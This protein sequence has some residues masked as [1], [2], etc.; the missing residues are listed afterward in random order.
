LFRP[1]PVFIPARRIFPD[2]LAWQTAGAN[3]RPPWRPDFAGHLMAPMCWK[4]PNARLARDN[5][6]ASITFPRAGQALERRS[7]QHAVD[8]VSRVLDRTHGMFF[9]S[10]DRHVPASHGLECADH[11]TANWARGR[12]ADLFEGLEQRISA[13]KDQAVLENA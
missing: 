12:A 10:L 13:C 5:P 2:R 1:E 8:P 3:P 6:C 11:L 4:I 9:A 7:Q